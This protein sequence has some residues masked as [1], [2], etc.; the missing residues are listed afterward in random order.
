M[1]MKNLNGFGCE[2]YDE[3]LSPDKV[4]VLDEDCIISDYEDFPT[5]KFSNR[6][7][8]QIDRNMKN[9]IIV[10]LLGRNISYGTLLNRFHAMWKP[11]GEI[12]LIDLENN[13]FLVQFEDARDYAMVLTDGP[14]TIFGNYLTVQPWSRIVLAN[15]ILVAIPSYVMQNAW[16]GVAFNYFAPSIGGRALMTIGLVFDGVANF[17][18]G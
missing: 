15:A 1:V 16:H 13:Y 2:S 17:G 5:I 10:R 9:V 14:W 7:H 4:I 3:E 18:R 12:H 8:D 11:K 6:V